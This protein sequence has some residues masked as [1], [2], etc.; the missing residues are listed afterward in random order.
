MNLKTID[1]LQERKVFLIN[2]NYL[3]TEINTKQVNIKLNLENV[4]YVSPY[5]VYF[6]NNYSEFQW[7]IDYLK[8]VLDISCLFFWN[9]KVNEKLKEITI[10]N[11]GKPR[12]IYKYQRSFISEENL[13]KET[14]K[15]L[16][17]GISCHWFF[18]GEA[19]N[20]IS[21]NWSYQTYGYYRYFVKY[22]DSIEIEARQLLPNNSVG[23]PLNLNEEKAIIRKT[24]SK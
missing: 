6:F 16:S 3:S 9:L 4:D 15:Y 19:D 18:G 20:K 7:I 14:R 2:Q 8:K 13:D 12:I 22:S 21:E 24:M 23:L 11:G 1:S 17:Q 10:Y 5:I